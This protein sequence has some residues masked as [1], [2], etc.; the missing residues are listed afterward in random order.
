MFKKLLKYDKKAVSKLWWIGALISFGSALISAFL[1]RFVLPILESNIQDDFIQTISGLGIT[2]AILS[3]VTVFSAG[4]FT[5]VLLFI[6]FYKHFFTDEGYLTF[7]LPVKRSTLLLSKTVNAAIWNLAH[8]GVILAA[9]VL[10]AI[11]AIPPEP[12]GPFFNLIVFETIG[13]LLS[14][15][16]ETIGGWL[17]VYIAEGFLFL[18]VSLIF[19]IILIQFCITFGSTVVKRAKL[20]LSIGIYYAISSTLASISQFMMFTFGGV[21]FG[22]IVDF[23]ED[24]TQNQICAAYACLFLSIIAA[25]AVISAVLYAI[26]QYMLDRKLNLA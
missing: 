7:T 13:A 26:T 18:F 16:W 23:M 17:I 22:G 10:F 4:I 19:S 15:S 5:E 3:L 1:F 12:N 24:A 20:I 14:F 25:F 6:R 11:I 2:A 9:M 21:L 8:F